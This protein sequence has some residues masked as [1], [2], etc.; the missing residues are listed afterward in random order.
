MSAEPASQTIPPHKRGAATVDDPVDVLVP[1][2]AVCREL[3]ISSMTLWRWDRDPAM[4][5]L[6]LPPAVKIRRR[7]FRFRRQLEQFKAN[8]MRRAHEERTA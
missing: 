8:L 2:P 5:A 4:A 1:D 3:A 7:N 6:G